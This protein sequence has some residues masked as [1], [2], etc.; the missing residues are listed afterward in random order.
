MSLTAKEVRPGSVK[1]VKRTD[2]IQKEYSIL[3]NHYF[4]GITR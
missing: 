1:R 4:R 2:F 3:T